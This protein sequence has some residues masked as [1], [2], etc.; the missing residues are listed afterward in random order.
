MTQSI[1]ESLCKNRITHERVHEP[2]HPLRSGL[3]PSFPRRKEEG[4]EESSKETDQESASLNNCVRTESRDRAHER[5]AKRGLKKR[6]GKVE[7]RGI[8]SVFLR[9]FAASFISE[10]LRKIGHR[11][12]LI[13]RV[14]LFADRAFFLFHLLCSSLHFTLTKSISQ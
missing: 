2:S 14:F 5:Q 6:N 4:E 11:S 10:S 13:L 9:H 12:L 7:Y 8:I 3:L 1:S